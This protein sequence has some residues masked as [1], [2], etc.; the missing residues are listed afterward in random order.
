MRGN[1]QIIRKDEGG[2]AVDEDRPPELTEAIARI[3]HDE[4]LREDVVKNG[5]VPGKTDFSFERD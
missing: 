1:G 4:L 3:L 5:L 2:L